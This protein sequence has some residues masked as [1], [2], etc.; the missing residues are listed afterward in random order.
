[1]PDGED[2]LGNYDDPLR[3]ERDRRIYDQ[4]NRIESKL[5]QLAEDKDELED[6]VDDV[7]ETVKETKQ[8]V[9]L[10]RKTLFGTVGT[11]VAFV[12][13]FFKSKFGF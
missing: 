3:W 1:M 2:N 6:T 9:S 5:D 8:K 10:H 4:L 7:E 11:V 13:A 12:V